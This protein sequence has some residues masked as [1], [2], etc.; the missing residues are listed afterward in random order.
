MNKLPK[1]EIFRTY[2][3]RGIYPQELGDS[4]AS[5][6]G[7]ALGTFF[8]R[9]N[10]NKCVVGRD[11]RESSPNMSSGFIKGLLNT[12]VNVTDVGITLTPAIHY[13]TSCDNFDFGINVTASHNP[14]E[15]NGFRIDYKNARPFY[16]DDIKNL[17]ELIRKN[18][19]EK[20]SGE[21]KQ[22]DLNEKYINSFESIFKFKKRMRVVI[23]CGYG[24]V[25]VFGKKI[26]ENSGCEVLEVKCNI[27][28]EFSNGVPD[29]ENK[30]F[31]LE[32]SKQVKLLK[33]DIGF[34]FDMDGDR[35]GVADEKGNIYENDKIFLFIASGL[36]KA[37]PGSRLYYDVKCS[38]VLDS[39]IRKMGGVP[40]MIKTGHPF[41]TE[42]VKDNGLMGCELSGHMYF[43]HQKD[44]VYDDG[45]YAA[46]MVLEMLEHYE[47]PF[48]V[49]MSKY[50]KRYHT[51]EIK[52]ACPDNIKFSIIEHLKSDLKRRDYS[53]FPL[54]QKMSD[55]VVVDIDGV[56]VNITETEWFLIRASNTSP[57]L[58]VR[59]EAVDLTKAL[60]LREIV[61]DTL[62]KFNLNTS[63]FGDVKIYYS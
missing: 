41:F 14:K 20:G 49:L 1:K 52:I 58:S 59:I 63:N 5:L 18:N 31:M 61:A 38:G 43:K 40:V 26:F 22:A 25:S 2:D 56:R 27:D 33:A 8:V 54:L 55:Y 23:D 36:L 6:I 37:H 21:Y 50:P 16:G 45:I 4:E 48:S 12:G 13:L 9:K 11:D 15:Y 19:F 30:A 7:S 39:E 29:P 32:L 34:A 35:F 10:F 3:I 62:K 60:V 53:C 24:A 51:N 28:S 57:Y 47:T 17:Y 44:V 46:C 42:S